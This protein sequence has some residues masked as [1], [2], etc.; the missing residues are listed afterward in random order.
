MEVRNEELQRNLT[1]LQASLDCLTRRLRAQRNRQ[2]PYMHETTA[3]DA[4]AVIDILRG[5]VRRDSYSARIKVIYFQREPVLDGATRSFLS[6]RAGIL[7]I[8]TIHGLFFCVAG[9]SF[10]VL[11][12]LST[13]IFS[14][15]FLQVRILSRSRGSSIS[16][17]DMI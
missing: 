13:F 6:P 9:P 16:H 14:I 8:R 4:G 7:E 17:H 2:P 1:Q 5:R 10:V 12:W 3:T 15:R 11:S